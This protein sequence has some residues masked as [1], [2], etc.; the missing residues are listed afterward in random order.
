[1]PRAAYVAAWVPF[2]VALASGAAMAEAGADTERLRITLEDPSGGGIEIGTLELRPEVAGVQTYA[3]NLDATGFVDKFLS[4][5][6]FRC[7]ETATG[8][9]CHLP[10]PYDKPSTIAADDLRNLE[11][12]LMFVEKTPE[13]YGINAWNGRYFRLTSTQDGFSGTLHEVDLNVLAAPPEAGVIYPVT[14]DMLHPADPAAHHYTRVR[15]GP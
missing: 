7:L 10:Y 3:L 9:L 2:I 4:M 5:R 13:E 1:M 6:P 11:Y 15:I 14:T 8:W 12:D